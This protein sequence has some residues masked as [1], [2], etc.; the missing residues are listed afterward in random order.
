MNFRSLTL[1]AA[2][3]VFLA[4]PSYLMAGGLTVPH[5]I[6]DMDY[7]D[8]RVWDDDLFNFEACPRNLDDDSRSGSGGNIPTK[9][10]I[11]GNY[12]NPF[13]LQTD[14]SLDIARDTHV[15]VEIFNVMGQ[16]VETIFDDNLE[17]G[18]YK[19]GWDGASYSSGLYFAKM[20]AE[21]KTYKLAMTLIK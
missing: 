5:Y 1:I 20:R 16:K 13:N 11:A 17:A 2:T 19:L 3:A 4:F 7:D 14:I 21:G 15:K 9:F 18:R 10:A 8:S 6:N 12:P